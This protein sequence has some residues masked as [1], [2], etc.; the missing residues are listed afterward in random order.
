M[1]KYIILDLDGTLYEQK[2]VVGKTLQDFCTLNNLEFKKIEYGYRKAYN[3]VKNTDRTFPSIKEF[4][5][6]VDNQFLPLINME[7]NKKNLKQLEKL[8]DK[9]KVKVLLNIKPRAGVKQFLNYTK[10]QG[11]KTIIFS[12]SHQIHKHIKLDETKESFSE[13]LKFKKKQVEKLGIQHLIDEV[14]STTKFGG[15]KPQ[16]KV[17]NNLVKYLNCN[18]HE[19][20]MIGDSYNDIAAKEIGM[21]TILLKNKE[22]KGPW[23][24]DYTAT[25][26]KEIQEIV[27]STLL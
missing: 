16:K 13:K 20:L 6:E 2:S 14:I 12:G 1:I 4:F 24:P 19:C 7:P 17:F 23:K 22:K 5:K 11:I 21:K 26:F 9:A 27:S 10:N 25:S 3:K 15:Y 8:A 18:P